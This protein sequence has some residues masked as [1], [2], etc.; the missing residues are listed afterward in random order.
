MRKT[1]SQNILQKSL[2]LNH[3]NKGV[4]KD[5]YATL[6]FHLLCAQD[7]GNVGEM[8]TQSQGEYT[9]DFSAI[10]HRFRDLGRH[11]STCL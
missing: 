10:Y 8:R 4:D 7:P 9:L 3:S 6:S 11:F 1:D 2:Q 5:A